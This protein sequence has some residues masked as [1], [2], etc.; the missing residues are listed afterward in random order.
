MSSVGK[1]LRHAAR[2]EHSTHS[3]NQHQSVVSCCEAAPLHCAAATLR[4]SKPSQAVSVVRTAV[5]RD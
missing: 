4:F 3:S 2:T 5:L 1:Q